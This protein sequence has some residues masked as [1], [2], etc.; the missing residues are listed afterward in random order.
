MRRFTCLLVGFAM[1]GLTV[2][3]QDIQITGKVT[4]ADDGSALPGVSVVVKGT[5]T[6]TSTSV[7]GEYSISVPSDATLLF[8]TIGMKKQEVVVGGRT[9]INVALETESTQ[10]DEIVVVAYG[11]TKK[12]SFTGAATTMKGENLEK[13]QTSNVAKALEGTIAGV[14]VISNSGQ[15]GDGGT[16]VVRGIGSISASKEP[17]IVVDGVPYEGELN[18]IPSTD[19][20]SIT[21]LKDAVSTSIYGA[22]GSNGVILITTKTGKDGQMEIRF[23]GKVGVNSRAIPNYD[24]VT[25]PGDYYELIWE[26]LRNNYV[27]GSGY[28]TMEAN[29]LASEN[30]IDGC[31]IYNVYKNVDNASLIDPV[32][33]KLNSAAT[34]TKWGN[35][36]ESEPFTNGIRQDYNLSLSGGSDKTSYYTSLTYLNDEGV[37]DGSEFERYSARLK[38]DH[39][40]TD[41][42]KVGANI[43][44]SGTDQNNAIDNDNLTAYSNVFSFSQMIAPIY[45]VYLYDIETGELLLDDNGDKQYDFG[46]EYTRPY[47]SEINSV[48]TNRD[49]LNEFKRDNLTSRGYAE[50]TFLKDFT[51]TANISYDLFNRNST[52]FDTPNGGDAASVGG[53]GYKKT[54]RYSVLNTNQLLNY[55]KTIQNNHITALVGHEIKSDN[56]KYLRAEMTNF[57]NSNNSEFANA[58]VYQDLTS[59]TN[60]YRLEG[61]FA[62]LEYD[63]NNKYYLSGSVRYDGSSRFAPDNRW[64]TFG[65]VGA[66]WL[67]SREN[68]MQ[69]ITAINNL[70][71]KA[72]YGTQGND[73]ILDEN[74]DPIWYAYQDLYE[75][76]RVD[77]EA[78]M[79]LIFR[80]NEDLT[81]EKSKNFNIG[82]ESRLLKRL[83]LDADFFIKEIDDMLY[84]SPLALSNGN[85]DYI[86]RNELDM[87]NTGFEFD[88]NIDIVKTTNIYWSVGVNG[89]HYKNEITRLPADKDQDGYKSGNYW[90]SIGG[91]VYDWYT[92]EYVGV[93]NATGLPQYNYYDD[94]TGEVSLVNETSSATLVN[95]EKS[96]IP[97]FTGGIRT[98]LEAYGFD[99]SVQTAFQIGGYVS[100]Y[101][102]KN[103]MG[104]GEAGENFH[105]D[106]FKRWTSTNSESDIP[107][108]YF[109]NTTINET[110]DRWLTKASYFSLR[111]VTLGYTL[112]E[113]IISKL[114]LKNMRVYFVLDNGLF[115]SKRKGLDPRQNLDGTTRF[116]YSALRTMSFG[117][118]LTM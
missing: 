113:D 64:G 105:K 33:G 62:R 17:L 117:I 25:D 102:Y 86:W 94:E 31:L 82:I 21:V 99:F 7:D 20:E 79:N 12:S 112:P 3:G 63:Y 101:G 47:A 107:M 39:Q 51:F 92:Y 14:Q 52:E 68:F 55:R 91:T 80:G 2:I 8:S 15:P 1:W 81:W 114:Y 13:M 87:K 59:Y 42:L 71:L 98:S 76:N 54:S 36:W 96:S 104:G 83:S 115:F 50:L 5:T 37:I 111:N 6:G 27:D 4:S 70:K 60:E 67:M 40:A 29:Q 11:K 84:Q 30:L 58:T 28:S 44:F 69:S 9:S 75:V 16:I 43:G 95:T 34:D 41:F 72:S 45:P 32:T 93:D 108:L 74:D 116:N 38:L 46:T 106:A 22:R 66:S 61:Y 85:P 109:E 23:D 49:N 56:Y 18:S 53:R 26:S 100:D 110:S 88:L 103:L 19:I 48:S 65:S 97:D 118:S 57:V 10:V 73:N 90:R 35:E 78:A 77:G 89:M 24:I